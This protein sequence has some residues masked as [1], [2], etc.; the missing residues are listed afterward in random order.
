ML[1]LIKGETVTVVTD[2][3][4]YDE[5]G[6][7]TYGEAT[8]EEVSNVVVAPGATA[9]LDASRP[10]G[11]TVAYTLCFPKT[12]TGELKG[13]SVE[14]RGE[15]LQVVGDPQRYTDANTPTPWNLTVEVTRTDG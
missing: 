10:E 8:R 6:E 3:V 4:T 13:R 12:F 5:L 15:A 2:G 7:P 14:V 1:S 9:D 11:V